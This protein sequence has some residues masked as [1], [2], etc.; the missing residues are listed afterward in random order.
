M[1]LCLDKLEC[2]HRTGDKTVAR[3]P[4]CA[5]AG[6]DLSGN[7]LVIDTQ[8]RFSCVVNPGPT[9]RAHR[10]RIFQLAGGKTLGVLVVHPADR[11]PPI[12]PIIPDVMGR[13]GRQELPLTYNHQNNEIEKESREPAPIVPHYD[14]PPDAKTAVPSVPRPE[15]QV[16]RKS[17]YSA[18]YAER[19]DA[20]FLARWLQDAQ[21]PQTF[22]LYPWAF[23][24][25]SA[26]FRS[27]LIADLSPAQPHARF[28]PALEEARRLKKLFASH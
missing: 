7:H 27:S 8:G 25:D 3:C 21:L 23:V 18:T 16:K 2:V 10:Q 15:P 28:R 1:A 19:M 13:L 22:A 24:Q 20:G 6:H 5:E 9:G 11:N 4:A 12:R 26:M 17:R 14:F